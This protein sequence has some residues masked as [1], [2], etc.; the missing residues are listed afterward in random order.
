ME[1]ASIHSLTR[2]QMALIL[3]IAVTFAFAALL[4]VAQASNRHLAGQPNNPALRPLLMA[5]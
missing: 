5:R 2:L 4:T 3:V 1:I